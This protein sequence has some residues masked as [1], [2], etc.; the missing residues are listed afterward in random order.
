VIDVKTP[1]KQ[2][3]MQLPDTDVSWLRVLMTKWGGKNGKPTDATLL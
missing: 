1:I 2:G 3:L